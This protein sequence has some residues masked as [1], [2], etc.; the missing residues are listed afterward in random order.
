MI[1]PTVYGITYLILTLINILQLTHTVNNYLL[2]L[3]AS[4]L[5]PGPIVDV[6]DKL[7]T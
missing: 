2:Y 3:P 4:I 7:R 6:T 5:I 1:A